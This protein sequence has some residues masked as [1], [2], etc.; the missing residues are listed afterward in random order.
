MIEL[1]SK[2]VKA[3]F[4]RAQ[5]RVASEK[6]DNALAGMCLRLLRYH[7]DFQS[8]S[9]LDLKHAG[10]LDPSNQDVKKEISR[11]EELKKKKI[12]ESN[13]VDISSFNQMFHSDAALLEGCT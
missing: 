10:V 12:A 13:E 2:N 6:F 3:W 1:D 7:L 11:T 4:R 5:A 9:D 8:N